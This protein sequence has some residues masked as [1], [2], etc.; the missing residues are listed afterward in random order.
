M[1]IASAYSTTDEHGRYSN[2]IRV[3]YYPGNQS[4]I[5]WGLVRAG[6]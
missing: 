1:K 3:K 2:A 5:E 4:L 6:W